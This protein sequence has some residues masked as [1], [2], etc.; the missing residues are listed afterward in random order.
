M[1]KYL[2]FVGEEYYPGAAGDLVRVTDEE[3]SLEEIKRKSKQF[4]S[5]SKTEKYDPFKS[6]E[7]VELIILDTETNEWER[8][9]LHGCY[10]GHPDHSFD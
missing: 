4:P 6:A 10:Y 7:Y 3:I 8:K 5:F 2:Y 9:L 1:K